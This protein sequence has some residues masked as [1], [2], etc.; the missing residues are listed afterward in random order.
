MTI[1]CRPEAWRA[2]LVVVVVVP[3][4]LSVACDDSD[5]PAGP[6]AAR[7]P[8]VVAEGRQIFRFDTFGDESQ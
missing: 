6:A 5:Q 2:A 4:I 7:D 1:R 8:A 3:A